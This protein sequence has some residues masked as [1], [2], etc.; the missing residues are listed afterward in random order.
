MTSDFK[1]GGDEGGIKCPKKSNIKEEGS[2]KS[3]RIVGSHLWTF[4]N[5]I[6]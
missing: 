2:R 1:G 6:K 4:P 3:L 5:D